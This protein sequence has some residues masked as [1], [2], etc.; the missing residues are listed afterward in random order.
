MKQF[1]E[2]YYV[3]SI[4]VLYTILGYFIVHPVI[5]AITEL[6]HVHED[7]K[8][9]LHWSDLWESALMAFD[10]NHWPM[11]VALSFLSGCLGFYFARSMREYRIISEQTKRFSQIGI[12]AATI[13]HDLTN[14]ITV[15]DSFAGIIKEEL[16]DPEQ[17]KY[18]DIIQNSTRNISRMV[19]DIKLV[20]LDPHA[21]HLVKEIIELRAFCDTIISDSKPRAK[22]TINS[23]PDSKAKIDSGYFERVIWN[24]VKNADEAL[25]NTPEPLIQIDIKKGKDILLS[26]SDNGPGIP[27]QHQKQLFKLGSTFGK[28][29]GTG[30]GLYSSKMIVEAHKGK[31]WFK[32]TAEKGTTFFIRLP[33]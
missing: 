32:S 23:D 7:G 11:A 10:Y 9:H 17:I 18:C 29:G 13:T 30:I 22:V 33:A 28:H 20:A 27:V 24:L 25:F 21:I 16:M 19:K 5:N 26:I 6:F 12:N 15:I 31:I 3:I 14:T 8:L 1:F 4:T 2:K